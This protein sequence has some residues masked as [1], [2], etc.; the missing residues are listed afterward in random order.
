[1]IDGKEIIL[2]SQT[3]DVIAETVANRIGAQAYYALPNK[4]DILRLYTDFDIITD[5][6]SDI[7][8]I[9]QAKQA[10]IITYN[11]R[12]QWERLL[13]PDSLHQEDN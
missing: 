9:R 12:S 5:N 4:E 13:P 11:N 1:M 10:T 3:M 8:L 7:A 2:V 6:F